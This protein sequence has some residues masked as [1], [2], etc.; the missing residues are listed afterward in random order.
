MPNRGFYGGYIART[1]AKLP[2]FSRPTKLN[3]PAETQRHL[4]PRNPLYTT[5]EQKQNDYGHRMNALAS[6][7]I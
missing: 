7:F 2:I 4:E 5:K 3:E 1:T 6:G